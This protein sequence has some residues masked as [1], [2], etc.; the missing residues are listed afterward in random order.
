MIFALNAHSYNP[1][2]HLLKGTVDIPNKQNLIIL[3]AGTILTIVAHSFDGSV[4]DHFNDA[5]RM[6]PWDDI[7]N[8]FLGTGIPGALIG[9]GTLGYGLKYDDEHS[10][11]SGQAHLEALVA[12]FGYTTLIKNVARRN[13]PDS[14]TPVSFPSGHT[15]T[16]FTSA[17]VLMDMYGPWV[18]VPALVLSTLTGISRLNADAHFL[19][20]VVFGATLGYIVGH[21]YT[22]HHLEASDTTVG[23]YPYYERDSYGMV[24]RINF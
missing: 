10:V 17:A 20:D 9:L 13:R 1:G 7:G 15:S 8:N 18:G 22:R 19:S 4:H 14:D 24:A 16:T 2:K 3:G 23:F 11:N 6:G 5:D 21:G 12:S